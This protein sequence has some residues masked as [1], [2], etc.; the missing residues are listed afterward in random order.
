MASVPLTLPP[1]YWQNITLSKKD[2][3]FINTF[4]FENET[5]LNESELVPVLVEERIRSESEALV[6]QQKSAGNIYLPKDHFKI[7]DKLVFPALDWRAGKVIEC[8]PGVN[9]SLPGLEVITVDFG[10][11]GSRLFAAGLAEHKL[12]NPVEVAGDDQLLNAANVLKAHGLAIEKKLA[13]MLT[14]DKDLVKVAA[15]WFPR[16]L[17]VDVNVGHLNLAEAV[18]DEAAGKPLPTALLLEQVGLPEKVNPK[19]IEFSLNYALQEDGRFD[20]VGPAGEVLWCLKRLEPQDVQQIPAPLQYIEIPYD[21]SAL[22]PAMLALESDLDDELA[23]DNAPAGV[24]EEVTISLNY[25]HWRA[26]TL[27]VSARVRGLFPT[28]YESP[29][30]RFTIV[31]GQSKEEI[32]AWVVRQHG[33]VSGLGSLYEKYGLM[34]GSLLAITRGK[35]PGQVIV[36][37]RIRRPTRDWVRTVLVGSDGGIVFA[38]LKQNLTSE[39][40]ERMVVAVPDPSGVD[41]ACEQVAKQHRPFEELV[42]GMMGELVKMN[43]QGHVHAQELYSAIN[44]LRRCPPGPLLAFLTGSSKY[45]HVGDLHYR[46]AETEA[47][48]D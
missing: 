24:A 34:P 38:M 7:G 41:E 45:K 40:N 31:D 44:I 4:L 43:V 32:P 33:Y 9:P 15:R 22:T 25:P 10:E 36:T 18:L 19:L 12:N 39:F 13:D 3:E 48:D 17:L 37:P 47:N 1:D 29:R 11:G 28:A 26:G 30:V 14:Q 46:L 20:E 42:A 5:P 16:A 35:K 6:K 21:R 23:E 8:R 27:P 2:L